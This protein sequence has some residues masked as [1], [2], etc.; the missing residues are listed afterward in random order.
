MKVYYVNE[1][2]VISVEISKERRRQRNLV[3][4]IKNVPMCLCIILKM[5]KVLVNKWCKYVRI[6][7]RKHMFNTLNYSQKSPCL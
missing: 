3:S 7:I 4:T 6:I 2:T 1:I 5:F